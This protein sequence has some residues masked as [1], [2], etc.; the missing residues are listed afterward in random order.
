MP[1]GCWPCPCLTH[2]P[3][4]PSG[5][6]GLDRCAAG[7]S[8]EWEERGQCLGLGGTVM[9]IPL[10]STP[11]SK[12]KPELA[13]S[14]VAPGAGWSLQIPSLQRLNLLCWERAKYEAQGLLSKQV[15]HWSS[16][17]SGPVLPQGHEGHSH[18]C[19]TAAACQDWAGPQHLGLG[20]PNSCV[21]T[22]EAFVLSWGGGLG[23]GRHALLCRSTEQPRALQGWGGGG[24]SYWEAADL[25]SP[26]RGPGGLGEDVRAFCSLPIPR[27]ALAGE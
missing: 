17:C 26:A 4:E 14:C 6:A 19:T 23:A 21:G 10:K 2:E 9:F 11:G 16:S 27:W 7:G 1:G 18:L 8:D 24:C 25:C 13:P 5:G 20:C 12:Q 22:G 15:L 3:A